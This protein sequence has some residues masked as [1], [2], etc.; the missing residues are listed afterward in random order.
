MLP[1]DYLVP[2][3][4]G[5][6][7]CFICIYPEAKGVKGWLL[8]DA[9]LRGYYSMYNYDTRRFGFSPHSKSTKAPI[10]KGRTP[11]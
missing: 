1:V 7:R 5:S 3:H 2:T 11:S 8:G 6:D 10:R 9:F 4:K